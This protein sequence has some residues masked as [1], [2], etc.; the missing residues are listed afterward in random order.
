MEDWFPTVYDKFFERWEEENPEE[1]VEVTVK[2]KTVLKP[3]LQVKKEVS[4]MLPVCQRQLI[5]Q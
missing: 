2:G 4:N 5:E 3:R 1:L